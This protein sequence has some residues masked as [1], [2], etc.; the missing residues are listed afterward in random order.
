MLASPIL[1]TR[2]CDQDTSWEKLLLIAKV[3]Q[4]IHVD[5]A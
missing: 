4:S 2:S 3:Q 1:D 5:V